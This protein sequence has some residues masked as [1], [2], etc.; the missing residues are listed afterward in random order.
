MVGVTADDS[1]HIFPE[2]P[3]K[4]A[5]VD[6]DA[7]NGGHDQLPAELPLLRSESAWFSSSAIDQ[8]IGVSN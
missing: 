6:Y 4:L 8:L 1:D 3:H 2:G 7:V 5:I